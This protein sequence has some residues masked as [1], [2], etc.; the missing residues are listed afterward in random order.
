MADGLHDELT[1]AH[2]GRLH[3]LA[4]RLGLRP[5]GSGWTT[6]R[7]AALI[8]GGCMAMFAIRWSLPRPDGELAG[9]PSLEV[10]RVPASGLAVPA[11]GWMLAGEKLGFSYRN[12]GGLRRLV[13]LGLDQRGGIHWFHPAWTEPSEDPVAVPAAPGDGPH[14]L[15][16]A[17][18]YEP[19]GRNLV[20]V[21]VFS[22]EALSVRQV[23]Q[24]LRNGTLDP[25]AVTRVNVPLEIRR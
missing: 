3:R 4:V 9:A 5:A 2:P 14:G 15:G 1:P 22:N 21:G 17:I 20:V 13:V 18:T 8:A 12:P 16:G 6:A 19:T 7:W 11:Q 24:R 23:E 10:F 25:P